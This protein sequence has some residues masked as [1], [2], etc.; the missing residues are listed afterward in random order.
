[1]VI[2]YEPIWAIGTGQAA[3]PEDAQDACQW[4]REVVARSAGAEA[5]ATRCASSTG[6]R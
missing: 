6:A 4:I 5:G 2:A 3:T 1:M